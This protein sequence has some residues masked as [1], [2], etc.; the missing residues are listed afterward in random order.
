MD[1]WYSCVARIGTASGR[2]NYMV[3]DSFTVSVLRIDR[4]V[5]LGAVIEYSS[6]SFPIV[7]RSLGVDRVWGGDDGYRCVGRYAGLMDSD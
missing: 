1:A 6:L 4:R 7:L 2:S 3:S 5:V